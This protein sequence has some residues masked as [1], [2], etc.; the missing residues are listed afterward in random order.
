MQTIG[1]TIPLLL[2][3]LVMAVGGCKAP[4]PGLDDYGS[5]PRAGWSVSED[6]DVQ[7]TLLRLDEHHDAVVREQAATVRDSIARLDS[8]RGDRVREIERELE[9]DGERLAE[10]MLVEIDTSNLPGG[11][12]P[13]AIRDRMVDRAVEEERR[14][15]IGKA[16]EYASIATSIEKYTQGISERP[17]HAEDPREMERR[18]TRR[19]E[20]VRIADPEL[21]VRL[22]GATETDAARGAR[23]ADEKTPCGRALPR[24]PPPGR[25][26]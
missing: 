25:T 21:G 6:R 17:K 15:A 8:D 14:G 18:L 22:G 7:S 20:L 19:L 2:G 3:T 13:D 11:E 23:P 12:T 24:Q 1:R 9:E 26:R 10:V 16:L 5:P 4:L